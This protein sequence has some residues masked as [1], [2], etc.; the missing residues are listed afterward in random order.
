MVTNLFL[1]KVCPFLIA[2]SGIT[3]QVIKVASVAG[4]TSL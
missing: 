3:H 1:Q 4:P 2:K